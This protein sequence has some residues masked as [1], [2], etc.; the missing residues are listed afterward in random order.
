MKYNLELQK[1]SKKE[2]N[3][4]N[5]NDLMFI[6]N[7]GRMGDEDGSTFIIKKNDNYI[8]YRVDG[9][10]YPT[11]RNNDNISLD[12]M[13]NAFPKWQDAWHNHS[14]NDKYIYIYMGFGNGLCVD[15]SIYKEYYPYLINEIKKKEP[16]IDENKEYDPS[17]NYTVWDIALTKMLT[18]KINK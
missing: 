4:L 8:S 2:F 14:N 11:N 5:E 12:D 6:T 15:K 17:I 16:T 18:D 13:F 3:N 1:I 10:M 7:P 9:W